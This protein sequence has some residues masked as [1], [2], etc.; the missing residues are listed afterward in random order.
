V[1]TTEAGRLTASGKPDSTH[2]SGLSL[3]AVAESARRLD[4][5]SCARVIGN[6]ADLVHAAQRAG[7]PLGTL[8]PAAV[9]LQRDGSIKLATAV[10]TEG[11]RFSIAQELPRR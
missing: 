6:A 3:Q 1:S 5:L 10:D 2:P 4:E 8:T 11:N 7:Q 9:L